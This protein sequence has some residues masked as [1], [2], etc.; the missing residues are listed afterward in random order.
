MEGMKA[1]VNAYQSV[2]VDA[3]VLGAS[4]HELIAKLLSKAMSSTVAAKG[5]MLNGDIDG[6]GAQIKI[7]VAIISD[8]LRA[9]LD[10]EAGGDLATNLD[11]LYE[12]MLQCLMTGHANNDPA[13]LDEVLSI[14]SEI[15]TGWDGIKP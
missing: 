3:A 4:P 13:P 7:A 9:S 6:K 8:G 2:Q 15:K 11:A 14:L 1:A 12:Y 5:L 10:M